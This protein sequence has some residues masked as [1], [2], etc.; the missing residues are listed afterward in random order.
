M[1]LF[2]EDTSL[3]IEFDN[4]NSASEALNDDLINI[5]QRTDQCLVKFSPSNTK[6]MTCIYKKKDYPPINF[7]STEAFNRSFI[8][9]A[10]RMWNSLPQA[11]CRIMPLTN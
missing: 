11:S 9:S 8:P 3:Y 10:I 6:L 7:N 1:T 5:Q 4:A 2:A